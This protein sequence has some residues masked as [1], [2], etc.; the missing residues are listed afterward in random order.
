MNTELFLTIVAALLAARMLNPL[1]DRVGAAVWGGRRA[2][3]T[4]AQAATNGSAASRSI[5]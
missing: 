4:S 1:A 2:A 3:A 5:P